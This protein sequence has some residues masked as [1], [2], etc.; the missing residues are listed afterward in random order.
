[1]GFEANS[2]KKVNYSRTKNSLAITI[3]HWD[4]TK[5]CPIKI[6]HTYF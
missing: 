6:I 4:P 1:M 2:H 5:L 3:I